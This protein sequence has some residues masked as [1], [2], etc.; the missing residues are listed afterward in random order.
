MNR[1]STVRSPSVMTCGWL[2]TLR[3]P[4]G[5][6][7]DLGRAASIASAA[8][9]AATVIVGDE[10]RE[11]VVRVEEGGVGVAGEKC[12]VPQDIHEQVAVR[13]DAVDCCPGERVARAAGRLRRVGAHEMT[14]ASIGS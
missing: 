5:T 12:L 7:S 1:N 3:Q 9:S 11:D 14:L 13:G 8:A 6:S 10:W 4:D 2:G